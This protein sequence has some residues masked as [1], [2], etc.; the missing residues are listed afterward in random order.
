MLLG[1]DNV[2]KRQSVFHP[3]C[4]SHVC[5]ESN[6]KI[7]MYQCSLCENTFQ[8]R[9]GRSKH[10]QRVHEGKNYPCQHC[11]K[12]YTSKENLIKHQTIAKGPCTVKHLE[13]LML[14]INKDDEPLQQNPSH[15]SLMDPFL[16]SLTS[17][18]ASHPGY[19]DYEDDLEDHPDYNYPH[20]GKIAG[21]TTKTKCNNDFF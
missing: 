12:T 18:V 17:T 6:T 19:M 4:Q 16:E 10:R 5:L 9:E 7:N 11:N 8:T 3:H 21:N 1:L 2:N 13:F 14:N 20:W 15:T